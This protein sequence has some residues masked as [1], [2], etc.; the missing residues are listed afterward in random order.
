M[1]IPGLKTPDHIGFTVPNLAEAIAFF[2]QHFGFELA[3]EFGPFAS[4][5]SWMADHLNVDPRAEISKIAVMNGNS[6]NL[7]IFEYADTVARNKVAPNNA[8]IGGHHLA[9]Y[10]DDMAAAVAYLKQQG[11]TV[12]GEPTQMTEGPSAGESWVYFLAPWG[13]QLEL[14]SYPAGKAYARH[15]DVALFDPR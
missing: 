2:Q 1:A 4:D 3:Y 6:I 9:F 8:D 15:S 13:M 7:E 5:D 11:L 12:L 14:V 10:V